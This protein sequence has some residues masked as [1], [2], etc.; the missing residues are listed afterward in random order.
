MM[1]FVEVRVT[2]DVGSKVEVGGGGAMA[3]CLRTTEF[4]GAGKPAFMIDR[5]VGESAI[6]SFKRALCI[7]AKMVWISI[8]VFSVGRGFLSYL[9]GRM[10]RLGL[11]TKI[12][13][14][15][16]NTMNLKV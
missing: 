2:I 1:V 10:L 14:R 4:V 6:S 7:I 16:F 11:A 13:A 12:I 15:L 8:D 5:I 9:E 3:S